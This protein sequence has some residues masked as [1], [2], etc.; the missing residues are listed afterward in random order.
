MDKL[1]G[2]LPAKAGLVNPLA[3]AFTCN[4]HR[5]K[6]L[7]RGIKELLFNPFGTVFEPPP[8]VNP[9]VQPLH[10]EA[11]VMPSIPLA[12]GILIA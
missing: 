9:L 6:L 1:F 8:A 4:I 10:L 12:H 7:S 2:T 5:K 11:H 3:P